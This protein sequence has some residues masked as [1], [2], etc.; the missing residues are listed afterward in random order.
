MVGKNH[1]KIELRVGKSPRIG[2]WNY[3]LHSSSQA[4]VSFRNPLEIFVRGLEKQVQHLP[5]PNTIKTPVK[6]FVGE[7]CG[8]QDSSA[9][10]N[11]FCNI[12]LKVLDFLANLSDRT[13]SLVYF[14]GAATH[15]ALIS[16][17]PCL[18][19][20]D[21]DDRRFFISEMCKVHRTTKPALMWICTE[22]ARDDFK[23]LVEPDGFEYNYGTIVMGITVTE[24]KVE[25]LMRKYVLDKNTLEQIL[26]DEGVQCWWICD[27]DFEGMTVWHKH[28]LGE[29]LGQHLKGQI[30]QQLGYPI[31]LFAD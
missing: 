15:S 30:L 4:I 19:L 9:T 27:S 3:Y 25:G 24:K 13:V 29:E 14:V 5:L 1:F 22:Y 11:I 16:V 8:W 28:H 7:Q 17:I 31:E 2:E 23:R 21:K 10:M 26:T 18:P 6:V 20:R 12:W